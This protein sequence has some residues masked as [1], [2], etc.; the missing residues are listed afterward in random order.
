MTARILDGKRIAQAVREDLK[1][2]AASDEARYGAPAGLAIVR[3]GQDPSSEV[4]TRALL[5]ASARI[6]VR[7]N[8]LTLPDEIDESGLRAGIEALNADSSIHGILMQLPLPPHLSQRVVAETIDSR[9]DVDGIS[10]RSAGNLFLRL[11][12]FVPSTCA[13][14]LE[15]L[16]R[17]TVRLDGERVVVVGASNVVG[18][19]LAFLLL[20]RDATVTVCHIYT[21]DLGEQTRAASVVVVAA[22]KPGLLTAA[23]VRPGATVID[24]GINVLPDGSLV[25]DVDAEGVAAVAGALSPVPGGVGQLTNLMLLKQTLLAR[26]RLLG[27]EPE[28]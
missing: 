22:G 7:A 17:S 19:P 6:G 9:K 23:M 4:Y 16:D 25:G 15:I 21:R 10:T 8:V 24:V 28:E 20:H 13:A 1:E 11:P 5:R 3:V 26:Q 18:K 27:G 14:V 2:M 12:T